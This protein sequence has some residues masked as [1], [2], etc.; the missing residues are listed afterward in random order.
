MLQNTASINPEYRESLCVSRKLC[1][2]SRAAPHR[3][4]GAKCSWRQAVKGEHLGQTPGLSSRLP[5]LP[6]SLLSWLSPS[7][8]V[9]KKGAAV[10]TTN[11]AW[12]RVG[13]QWCWSTW[14]NPSGHRAQCHEENPCAAPAPA[15]FLGPFHTYCA[16]LTL[17]VSIPPQQT[18][19]QVR[20][21]KTSW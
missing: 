5:H 14:R 11:S 17:A 15:T 12:R 9:G 1:E 16:A 10:T 3:P 2:G 8:L 19:P 21:T 6:A 18:Q 13:A 4:W 20:A 7:L